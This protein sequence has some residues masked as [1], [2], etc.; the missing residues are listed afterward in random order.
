M[1]IDNVIT[2]FV[3][4]RSQI[5][6]VHQAI[7]EQSLLNST[8]KEISSK[9]NGAYR[10]SSAVVNCYWSQNS[11]REISKRHIETKRSS[12]RAIL[13]FARTAKLDGQWMT[14]SVFVGDEAIAI[15]IHENRIGQCCRIL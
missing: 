3:S 2:G 5:L 4:N 6:G 11:S 15:D 14:Q 12:V 13:L 8:Q 9:T 10:K 1:Q 7:V